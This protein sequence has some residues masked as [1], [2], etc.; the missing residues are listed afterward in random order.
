M[1][2]KPTIDQIN[3]FRDERNWR[4]FH[5]A[6]DLA[7]SISIEAAELLEDFQWV[8]ADEGV[9]KNLANIKEEIADV[10]IYTLM[11]SDNLG[12]DVEEIIQEKLEKNAIKYPIDKI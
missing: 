8:S 12:L 4:P 10:L 6:K 9:E 3:Q 2:L 5:N 1:S 11:L 7:I